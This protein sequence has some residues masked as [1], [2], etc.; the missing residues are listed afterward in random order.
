MSPDEARKLL[1]TF[2][3][4]TPTVTEIDTIADFTHGQD[5]LQVHGGSDA[6]AFTGLS[7]QNLAVYN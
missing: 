5:I 4:N 3:F 6:T 1:D 7:A 2:V